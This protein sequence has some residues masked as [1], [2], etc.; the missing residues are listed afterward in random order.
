M[1][2][3]N[4]I[5]TPGG[6]SIKIGCRSYFFLTRAAMMLELSAFMENPTVAEDAY[7]L[8]AAELAMRNTCVNTPEQ[9]MCPTHNP[10][11]PLD[12]NIWVCTTGLMPNTS[13]GASMSAS[14]A[15]STSASI[16]EPVPS[17]VNRRSGRSR[18]ANE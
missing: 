16:S 9:P 5:E 17:G 13:T 3:I 11:R 14:T 12:D 15:A 4:I 2:A 8:W 7:N 10:E 18:R 1:Y 6:Y